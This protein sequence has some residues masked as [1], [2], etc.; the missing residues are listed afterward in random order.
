MV[1]RDLRSLSTIRKRHPTPNSMN[2]IAYVNVNKELIINNYRHKLHF[3]SFFN[4]ITYI[5]SFYSLCICIYIYTYIYIN[6]YI[7]FIYI[8]IFLYIIF[9]ENYTSYINIYIKRQMWN[10]WTFLISLFYKN[11][12]FHYVCSYFNECYS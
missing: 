1:C 5:L 12:R 7:Y 10:T 11:M 4:I 9:I 3:R 2:T 6:T 8:Y